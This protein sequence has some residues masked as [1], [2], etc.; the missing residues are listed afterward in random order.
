MRPS[1]ILNVLLSFFRH[2]NGTLNKVCLLTDWTSDFNWYRTTLN[3]HTNHILLIENMWPSRTLRHWT[4]IYN[5]TFLFLFSI[6]DSFFVSFV[7]IFILL[8]HFFFNVRQQTFELFTL[9]TF[10]RYV[11]KKN[12]TRNIN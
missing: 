7:S 6:K 9:Y 12:I 5:W 1:N 11:Y 10:I 4:Y 3:S 2:F 8:Y